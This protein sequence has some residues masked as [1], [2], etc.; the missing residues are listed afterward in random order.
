MNRDVLSVPV[1][2]ELDSV[3]DVLAALDSVAD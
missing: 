2:V 1:V 3:P